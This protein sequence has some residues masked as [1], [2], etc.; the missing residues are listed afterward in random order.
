MVA[1]TEPRQPPTVRDPQA[2]GHV[3]LP[4]PSTP[5]ADAGG[6]SI[7]VFGR[8]WPVQLPR[9]GDPRLA[10][11]AVLVS[12]QVLGQVA[13]DF[14]LSI[15][16]ILISLG[17]AGLVDV[18]II[19]LE[20]G[21]IAWPASALLTGNGVALIMR[22]PGTE[23]GDWWS[24]RGWPIFAATAAVAVLSK[25]V[26][27]VQGRPLLNPSNGA[28]VVAFLLFGSN[29]ADPQDL[30]WGPMTPGLALTYAV[31][32]GGGLALTRRLG[33]QRV[34]VPFLVTFAGGL[35]VVAT[36]GHAMTARWHVGP[37]T[38]WSWWW[39]IVTSPELLVFLFFMITD[40][41]TAAKGRVGGAVYG[42]AVGLLAAVLMAAQST[43]FATKVALLGALTAVCVFRP[44]IERL[45]PAP[46]A[47]DDS[48][49]VVA[50]SLARRISPTRPRPAGVAMG[51]VAIVAAAA[52][53]AGAGWSQRPGD[54]VAAG[55][56]PDVAALV[57]DLPD[58]GLDPDVASL[59]PG[60][61]QAQAE[62]VLSDLAANLLIEAEAIGSG[63]ESPL[64]AALVGPR[65]AAARAAIEPASDGTNPT[66]AA[67]GA[68][69]GEAPGG[70]AAPA[71]GQQVDFGAAEVTIVRTS[72]SP[73]ALPSLAV[74]ADGEADGDPFRSA[75]V[76]A[77][78]DDAWLLV[79]VLDPSSLPGQ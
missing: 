11:A 47:E 68:P 58:V 61:D 75:F 76:M 69:D 37:V 72:D 50:T 49:R 42:G 63:D 78:G 57:G 34:V 71:P 5:P 53:C 67:S 16:Q 74:I 70:R 54:D 6:P 4:A 29:L 27:R 30:W 2:T 33:T 20:R 25:Y 13:I 48:L 19:A 66:E 41:P 52:L 46:R 21:V 32:L 15:A 59:I 24:T 43:E 31:I 12:V 17:V 77:P 45:A 1:R 39:V 65:L 44:L 60:F 18:V 9:L 23:H 73:Q 62:T 56:R 22:V 3:P 40:P 35:A 55:V 51:G 28:L 64:A 79:D 8:T 38:G 26:T 14:D 7:T 36:M 10:V